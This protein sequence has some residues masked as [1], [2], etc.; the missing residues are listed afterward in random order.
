MQLKAKSYERHSM[1]RGVI[2]FSFLV[3]C[4]ESVTITGSAVDGFQPLSAQGLSELTHSSVNF[5]SSEPKRRECNQQYEETVIL[6]IT[7]AIQNLRSF[8]LFEKSLVTFS[9]LPTG[10][11]SKLVNEIS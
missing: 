6:I 1:N 5:I 3:H 9:A 11:A 7:L 4:C 8:F 2:S 10:A